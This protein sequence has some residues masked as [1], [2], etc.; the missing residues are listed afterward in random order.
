[1]GDSAATRRV[2]EL[3]AEWD[4]GYR[5]GI[6]AAEAKL[7]EYSKDRF[8]AAQAADEDRDDLQRGVYEGA[9]AALYLVRTLLAA[10]G[11]GKETG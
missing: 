7:A 11:R 5:A 4:R 10:P 2:K 8:S 6:E 1:M 9:N 3:E